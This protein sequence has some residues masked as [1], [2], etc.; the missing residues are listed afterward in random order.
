MSYLL[1]PDK[2]IQLFL[3][4]IEKNNFAVCY[5]KDKK[6]KPESPP[7]YR[8][9]VPISDD[10]YVLLCLIT[11]KVENIVNYYKKVKTEFLESTIEVDKNDL[12]FLDR[13]SII[14]C[15]DARLIMK[16]T[17]MRDIEEESFKIIG[18]DNQ[19]PDYLKQKI[20][21][22]IQTSPYVKPR[23]KKLLIEL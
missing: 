2:Q 11:S 17:L 6:H 3:S 12:A 7:H 15:N 4:V 22:A 8:I 10:C 5:F 20:I 9:F 1:P 23:I 18:L 16:T 21:K 13:K 14:D 19:I